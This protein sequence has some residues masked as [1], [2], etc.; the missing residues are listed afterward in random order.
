MMPA[1]ISTGTMGNG[2]GSIAPRNTQKPP[3]FSNFL[4]T[5]SARGLPILRSSVSS[6]PFSASRYVT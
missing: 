5:F 2:G 3:C 4:Y 1:A 6:P